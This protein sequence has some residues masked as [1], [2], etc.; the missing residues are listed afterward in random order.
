M[1]YRQF[2]TEISKTEVNLTLSYSQADTTYF[3]RIHKMKIPSPQVRGLDNTICC[4]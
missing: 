4:T 2:T 3:R 1:C